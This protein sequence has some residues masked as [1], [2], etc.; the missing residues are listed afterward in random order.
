MTCAGRS[1]IGLYAFAAQAYIN[2]TLNALA[3][4]EAPPELPTAAQLTT[5]ANGFLALANLTLTQQL[6]AAFD[7]ETNILQ[8]MSGEY[9]IGFLRNPSGLY[10]NPR[11]PYDFALM[12][13][14]D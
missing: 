9:A 4:G 7:I 12:A 13:Q 1:G 3:E 6:G 8:W 11:L 5:Q 2:A 10:G 14:V